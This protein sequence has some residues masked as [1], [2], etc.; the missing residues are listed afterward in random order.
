MAVC[1]MRVPACDATRWDRDAAYAVDKQPVCAPGVGQ[2]HKGDIQGLRIW[3]K[4]VFLLD[5]F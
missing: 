2:L 5:F 4:F 1:G 3:R